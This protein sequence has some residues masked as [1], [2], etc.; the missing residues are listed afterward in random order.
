MFWERYLI[1]D[2][3]AVSESLHDTLTHGM[4][5]N[6]YVLTRSHWACTG[7][8]AHGDVLSDLRL[9]WMLLWVSEWQRIWLQE[10]CVCVWHDHLLL[11][12]AH[13]VKTWYELSRFVDT[14]AWS[15][16]CLSEQSKF[17]SFNQFAKTFN[18][19]E[20]CYDDLKNADFVFMRWKVL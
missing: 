20:F 13:Q 2:W 14:G 4:T 18:T 5:C 9:V 11:A 12:A 16:V 3:Y 10:N 1:G 19:D 7:M 17:G 6:L 8:C 15:N